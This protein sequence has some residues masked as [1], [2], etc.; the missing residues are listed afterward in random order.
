[1]NA[2]FRRAAAAILLGI[3]ATLPAAGGSMEGPSGEAGEAPVEPIA[4]RPLD[5]IGAPRLASVPYPNGAMY[6]R[7][8][9]TGAFL[10]GKRRLSRENFLFQWQGEASYY[11]TPWF[12][13]GVAFR[14]IAGEPNSEKQKIVNHYY[15][16]AR[17][18][19]AWKNAA[20]YMGPQIGVG[21]TNILTDSTGI[22]DGLKSIRNTKPTLALDCGGGWRFSPYL[23][24]TLGS[25]IEYSM[26][27]EDRDG[28][29]NTMNL[30]VSPGLALD[31][32]SLTDSLYKLVPA[33]Y[34]YAEC[35][36]GFLLSEATGNRKDVAYV[37]G[38]GL[39]F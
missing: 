12:S 9:I 14:I 13:G 4:L 3:L 20:V 6:I 5:S 26:V 23:G 36:M 15:G 17:F 7:Q 24:A 37:I 29:T 32:L 38:V 1:M 39:A 31:V 35:Q 8:G 33:L 19:K 30:H 28:L 16:Q 2:R 11:Y 21:N 10:G 34:V 25:N 22:K 27:D 18:H